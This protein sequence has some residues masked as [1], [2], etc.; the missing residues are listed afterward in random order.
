MWFKGKYFKLR[1]RC[2]KKLDAIYYEDIR[3][4]FANSL[5][6]III[7]IIALQ[8][9]V[10]PWPLFQFL[11]PIYSRVRTPWMGD[12]PFARPLPTH[13]TTKHRINAHNTDIH[14]LS[15]VRTHDP[16]VR[17]SDDSS[18]L[19]PRGLCDRPLHV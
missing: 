13:R 16:S 1:N 4:S 10:G 3:I 19:T 14:A 18:Y 6:I 7:I 12:Q 11:D 8:P 2:N 5:R 15:E 9:F 17:A